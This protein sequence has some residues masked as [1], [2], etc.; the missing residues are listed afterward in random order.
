MVRYTSM[1]SPCDGSLLSLTRFCPTNAGRAMWSSWNLYRKII[2]RSH[3]NLENIYCVLLLLVVVRL[4]NIYINLENI[5]Y[6]PRGTTTKKGDLSWRQ[7]LHALLCGTNMSLTHNV[8]VTSQINLMFSK[9]LHGRLCCVGLDP[10]TLIIVILVSLIGTLY[11]NF[12][13]MKKNIAIYKSWC[14]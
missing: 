9:Y 12:C 1:S 13:L 14:R 3:I 11:L 6:T 5:C 8:M 2:Q 7:H 10:C 4:F